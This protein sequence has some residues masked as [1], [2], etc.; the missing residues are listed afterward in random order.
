M[1][2]KNTEQFIH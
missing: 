1:H 2:V